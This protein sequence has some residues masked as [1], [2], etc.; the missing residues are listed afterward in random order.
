MGLS[1]AGHSDAAHIE[2]FNLLS[3]IASCIALVNVDL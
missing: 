1:E 3:P 2:R